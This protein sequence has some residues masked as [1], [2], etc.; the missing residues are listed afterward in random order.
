MIQCIGNTPL[1]ELKSM[2]TPG[3]ARIVAKMESHNPTGSMKDRMALSVVDRAIATGKL[4]RE[5]TLV[6]YTG[7]S[8]GTSLAFVCTSYGIKSSLVS[9]DAFS[10]EKRDHM[11]A[12]GADVAEIPSENGLITEKL[13]KEMI[14]L[15]AD[16]SSTP[17]AFFAD[18]FN[19]EDAIAGYGSLAEEAWKQTNQKIDVFV[20]SVGTAHSIAGVAKVLRAYNPELKVVAVEP[21]E[22]PVLSGGKS[23]AHKIEGVGVG[24]VPPLWRDDIADHITHVSTTEAMEMSRRL[25]VQEAIFVGTSSGANVVAALNEAGQ[26]NEND[27]V[28]TIFCDSGMK[29]LSTPLYS[30]S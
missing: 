10:R 20:H 25:A 8:T 9:S 6:E 21:A 17:G 16:L 26:L 5:G 23:G 13:I 29:Y 15:A 24:F 7:G 19:N 4:T 1:I 22:S 27:T 11:R 28:L 18:Q 14:D 12:L 3:S 2:R 30:S